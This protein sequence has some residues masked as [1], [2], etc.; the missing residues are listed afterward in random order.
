M[1]KTYYYKL[2]MDNGGAPCVQDHLLS[3]AICK[4]TIRRCAQPGDW[5]VGFGAKNFRVVSRQQ[6]NGRLVPGKPLVFM[7]R[8]TAKE[9]DGTYYAGGEYSHRADCI[10]ERNGA[11]FRRRSNAIYHE[12]PERLLE[13]LGHYPGY[14]SSA[15][16]LSDDFR[17]LPGG[18]TFAFELKFPSIK[19]AFDKVHR[20]HGVAHP[21]T[22]LAEHF[23]TLQRWL[24]CEFPRIA[25]GTEPNENAEVGTDATSKSCVVVSKSQ[26]PS[27]RRTIRQADC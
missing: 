20:V 11:R 27:L 6:P 9:L 4:P 24:W 10:Y 16:L 18:G 2:T 22:Q 7:A 12:A 17:Y 25:A 19:D 13:D 21:G 26:M 8:V 14:T 15:V 1:P 3:L 23:S 5:I